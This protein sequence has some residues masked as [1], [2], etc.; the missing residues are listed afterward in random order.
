MAHLPVASGGDGGSGERLRRRVSASGVVPVGDDEGGVA[1]EVGLQPGGDGV[2]ALVGGPVGA[3]R[4]EGD[5]VGAALGGEVAAE[6]EHVRPGGQ[7]QVVELG[8]LAEAEACGDVAAGVV[9]DGQV[10][11]LVGRG[12]AAVEGAGAFGGLGGVLGDVAGDLG[13]GQ[14]PGGGDRADVELAAP[15]QRPGGERW[16]GG[17][18]AR[19]TARAAW[20]MAS[21]SRPRV[22]QAGGASAG[23]AGPSRRMM[24]WKW[25]TPRRW[26]SATLA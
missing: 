2:L 19:W 6:A 12:D 3:Q 23:P 10:G 26:Y 21:V 1:V 5:G 14:V 9:A 16:R 8:E 22:A 25:T 4:A 11:Q 18:R 13:V 24:A 7:P 17:S 20:S 15:G